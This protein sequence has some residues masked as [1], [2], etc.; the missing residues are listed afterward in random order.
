ML[1][2]EKMDYRDKFQNRF[3][4]TYFALMCGNIGEAFA[5]EMLEIT[6]EV[7]FYIRCTWWHSLI[8]I[9]NF[10]YYKIFIQNL[11]VCT[12]A[13]SASTP[14]ASRTKAC[15][16]SELPISQR[17]SQMKDKLVNVASPGTPRTK[18]KD[19][20]A[21]SVGARMS[22]WENMTSSNLVSDIKKVIW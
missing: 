14:A 13:L 4:S 16:P 12:P 7:N 5:C 17:M 10:S 19:P 8:S 3:Y 22:A 9:F 2:R 11:Q 1:N 20:T 18:E 15:D 21:F 6:S